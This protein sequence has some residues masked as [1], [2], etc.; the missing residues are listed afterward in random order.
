MWSVIATQAARA[1][2]RRAASRCAFVSSRPPTPSSPSVRTG[3]AMRR[4]V[5]PS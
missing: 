1:D 3:V 5:V 4:H 2:V